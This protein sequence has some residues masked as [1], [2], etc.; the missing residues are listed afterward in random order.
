MGLVRNESGPDGGARVFVR[1]EG[2]SAAVAPGGIISQ[3]SGQNSSTT[4]SQVPDLLRIETF[5][6][7]A[8]A[9]SSVAEEGRSVWFRGARDVAYDLRPG[10]FRHPDIVEPDKLIE[11]EWQLLTDYR[12]QAPPFATMLPTDNLSLLFIMQHYR[13]PTR[14]LDWTEN[15]FIALFFATENAREEREGEEKD[16]IVWILDP[17]ALNAKTFSNQRDANRVM[18]AADM[19]KQGLA[20]SPRADAI[21]TNSPCALFGI[22]NSPRIVAQRGSFVLYGHDTS[23]LEKQNHLDLLNTGSLRRIV[24]SAQGKREIF[25]NLFNTGISDSVVYPD[26]DGLSREIR[27]RRGFLK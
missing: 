17:A 10:L 27:N 12:Y 20:P 5:R 8:D 21:K 26:L 23:S 6:Q 18:G 15:P 2:E 22:H 11:L 19:E 4:T 14:L 1:V 24:I 7:F 3:S 25:R 9:I 13:V 16:A